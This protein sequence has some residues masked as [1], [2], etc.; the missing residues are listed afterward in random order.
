MKYMGKGGISSYSNSHL[1]NGD[2]IET[3]G[4]VML[5]KV[6]F[7]TPTMCLVGFNFGQWAL[8]SQI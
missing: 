6:R 2:P 1:H 7:C 4:Q 8:G 3:A 5:R